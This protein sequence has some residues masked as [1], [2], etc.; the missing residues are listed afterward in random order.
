MAW[1]AGAPDLNSSFL[2][3]IGKQRTGWGEA[4]GD[5]VC[6]A[7]ALSIS[8]IIITAV[9]SNPEEQPRRECRCLQ[10]ISTCLIRHI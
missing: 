9:I 6:V 2:A 10:T 1:L 3:G 5:E 8:R 4:F 7:Y